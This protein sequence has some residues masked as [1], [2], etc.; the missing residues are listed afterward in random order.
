MD[1]SEENNRIKVPARIH[2]LLAKTSAQALILRRG[3][4]RQ[5]AVISWNRRDDT[6]KVGQW[7][8]G[9]I[10][11]FRSDISPDGKHWIYFA[12]GKMGNTWTGVAKVPYF[13]ASDFYVK[14]DSWN[15]GGLFLSDRKYWLN[16]NG[17]LLHENRRK[18][19][20]LEVSN[21]YPGHESGYGECPMIYFI[22]LKRDG[23]KEESMK[24]LTRNETIQTFSKRINHH[25]TMIK[26]FHMGSRN[27]TGKGVYYEEH[28]LVN[29]QEELEIP[30]PDWEWADL[31]RDRLIWAEKGNI[32]T[33]VMKQEGLR[34]VKNLYCCNELKFVN[35]AAP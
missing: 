18:E 12:M 11:H 17:V 35:I 34:N 25:W 23:W 30:L 13:R 10:Y 21:T 15:G 9:K 6:F 24:A 26:I 29:R 3:P 19:S 1:I 32:C 31:D 22:R 16:N 5:T 27:V 20:A 7:L 28:R 2:I 8:K 14:G 4:S 33:G